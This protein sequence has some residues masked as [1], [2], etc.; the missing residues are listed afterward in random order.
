MTHPWHRFARHL[1]ER[2]AHPALEAEGRTMSYEALGRWALGISHAIQATGT[3]SPFVGVVAGRGAGTYA[4]LLGSM[5]AGRGHVPIAPTLPP[6]RQQAI[7]RNAGL[8]LLITDTTHHDAARALAG[9]LPHPPAVIVVDAVKPSP[10]DLFTAPLPGPYAYMLH[11]SGSTGEPK[12][13]PI[14][15]AQLEAYL[16]HAVPL[17]QAGPQDRFTQLFELDFDLSMH[18]LWVC[19]SAGATLC[20][21]AANQRLSPAAF[22]RDAAITQWFSVPSVAMLMDRMRHLRPNAFPTLRSVAFCGE[23][24]PLELAMRFADAAPHARI[25][26][27]YGPTETTIAIAAY[28]LQRER[29]KALHG[30]VSI[31]KPFAGTP[32]CVLDEHGL[33]GDEGELLLGGDQLSPGYWQAPERDREAFTHRDGVR[34]YR[35]GDRVRVDADGDLFFL[36]RT[37]QQVKVRGHRVELSAI[38]H[39]L[40]TASG[41]AFACTLAHPVVQGIATGLVAFLPEPCRGDGPRLLEAC[42]RELPPH[43]LPNRLVFIPELPLTPNGKVDR[44]ALAER[45]RAAS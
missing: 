8:R 33:P 13:V 3:E 12:G 31:G 44:K 11:T 2:P 29:P 7:A 39:V 32:W 19:W 4:A 27:L 20:V 22:V 26:D 40:R 23:A 37:D 10:A 21:P 42:A 24:L 16:R 45:L 36:G 5:H 35:T 18:D 25:I 34:L 9:S 17:I 43:A 14:G 41:A 30:T 15:H 28:T 1:H 38:D 6:L